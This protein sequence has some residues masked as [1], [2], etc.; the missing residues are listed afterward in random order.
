[1]F[2]KFIISFLS[3]FS[4]AGVQAMEKED[5][6]T[7][8]SKSS[9]SSHQSSI[10]QERHSFGKIFDILDSI[11]AK[12]LDE[13]DFFKQQE[14]NLERGTMDAFFENS[15]MP[16]ARNWLKTNIEIVEH[17]FNNFK[18]LE[19]DCKYVL[20]NP[21]RINALFEISLERHFEYLF[22][23]M[24]SWLAYVKVRD[25]SPNY[26]GLA[27]V[28][29]LPEVRVTQSRVDQW[30]SQSIIDIFNANILI[31]KILYVN[32]SLPLSESAKEM[33][34]CSP[35]LTSYLNGEIDTFLVPDSRE[36]AES[37]A[38]YRNKYYIPFAMYNRRGGY[39][40]DELEFIHRRDYAAKMQQLKADPSIHHVMKTSTNEIKSLSPGINRILSDQ[41]KNE[42]REERRQ[43]KKEGK[44]ARVQAMQQARQQAEER[45]RQFLAAQNEAREAR[46][47]QPETPQ[48]KSQRVLPP[49]ASESPAVYFD[50]SH[51]S[52]PE[53][54]VIPELR[55]KIKTKGE[56][57]PARTESVAPT[58][59]L[60]AEALIPIKERRLLHKQKYSLLEDFWSLPAG[61]AY[62]NFVTLFTFL[63]GRVF[64]NGAGSSHVRLEFT[65]PDGT[66]S[67]GGTWRPHPYPIFGFHGFK[68]L[69]KYFE[70]CGLTFERFGLSNE[71]FPKEQI[72]EPKGRP[73]W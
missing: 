28:S 37:A 49:N 43:A 9:A 24:K 14:E 11:F 60:S 62:D 7:L 45:N 20:S 17:N 2:K 5:I 73:E 69:R 50:S 58:P 57:D 48:I 32:L 26:V 42:K 67:V 55:E 3:V 64:E 46:R 56:A 65:L 47:Q 29:T 41:N 38:K 59:S 16:F 63:G 8:P 23:R 35:E 31:L 18:D 40:N 19:K 39:N 4:L 6:E 30:A 15:S 27:P 51:P 34:S 1:M 68:A 12:Y 25:R 13:Q 66:I 10:S 72:E 70:G 71:M 52:M 54:Y 21:D 44:K 33:L 61:F 22:N 36:C 53:K